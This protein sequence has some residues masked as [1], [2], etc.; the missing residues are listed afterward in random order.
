MTSVNDARIAQKP[1]RPPILIQL[2]GKISF[3]LPLE[4]AYSKKLMY[5]T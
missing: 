2:F 4:R 1:H 3:Q 5:T